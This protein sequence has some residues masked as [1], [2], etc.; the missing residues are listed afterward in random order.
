[1][2]G[3]NRVEVRLHYVHTTHHTYYVLNRW[4]Y[5]GFVIFFFRVNS[6]ISALPVTRVHRVTLRF[7]NSKYFCAVWRSYS[8]SSV[9]GIPKY[10]TIFFKLRY[11]VVFVFVF[12][13]HDYYIPISHDYSSSSFHPRSPQQQRFGETGA[14][15]AVRPTRHVYIENVE[16]Q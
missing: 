8:D 13:R 16:P 11:T 6:K 5:I 4:P 12:R 3:K 2:T 7:S 14:Q 9:F 10:L 15:P 1:M